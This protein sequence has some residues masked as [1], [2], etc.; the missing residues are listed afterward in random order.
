M[1]ESVALPHPRDRGHRTALGSSGGLTRTLTRPAECPYQEA[2]SGS[3]F[4]ESA[5][6]SDELERPVN[7]YDPAARI[8]YVHTPREADPWSTPSDSGRAYN[9]LPSGYANRSPRTCLAHGRTLQ[10]VE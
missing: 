10:S 2:P 4:S 5:S 1:E 8:L 3:L 6:D 7:T 9:R